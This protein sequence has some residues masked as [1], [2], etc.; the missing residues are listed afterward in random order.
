MNVLK[1]GIPAPDFSL[2]ATPD[3]KVSL[4]EF[5][6]KP[7]VL[8]FYPGD[9]SPVCGDQLDLYNEIKEEFDR[10]DAMLIGISVDSVWSHLAFA[11]DRKYRFTLLSDFEP[12]GATARDYGVYR[13]REG[14]CERAL[15]VIDTYGIIHWSYVSPIGINPGADGILRAL[16]SLLERRVQA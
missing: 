5:K 8:V 7:V 9:W 15:F 4:S 12:K 16:E 6:G 11:K 1:P 3:Q 10:F 13:E 14:V 2:L